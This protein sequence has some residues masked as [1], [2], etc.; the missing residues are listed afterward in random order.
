MTFLA[1]LVRFLFW[2]LVV[3]WSAWLLR[4]VF[5]GIL[6]QSAS[7]PERRENAAAPTQPSGASRRLVRDPNCGLHVDETLSISFREGGELR[8]FCSVACRDAYTGKTKKLAANA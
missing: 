2:V 6:Q 3:W 7:V 5:S 8:H 4:R 1:R